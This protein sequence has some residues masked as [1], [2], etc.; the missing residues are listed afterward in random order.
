MKMLFITEK[1]PPVEGGS[2]VYY[3][4][5][6][7]NYIAG[8]IVILTKK[9]EGYKDFD[10]NQNMKIIRKGRPLPNWKYHQIFRMLLT[11]LWTTYL[12]HREKIDVIHCGDFMPAGVIGLLFKK[13]LNKPYVFYVHEG[14]YWYF[15]RYRFKPKLWRL[16]LKNADRIVAA[17]SDAEKGVKHVLN[18]G[19]AKIFKITPGVDYKK[20]KPGWK[21]HDLIRELKLDEKKVILTVGRLVDGRKGHDT[22]IRAMPKILAEVPNAVYLIAGRGPNEHSLRQLASELK[23]ESH[24]KFLGFIPN[25]MIPNVYSVCDVFVMIS[26]ETLDQGTEGFGMVFTEASATGKPVVGGRSGGNED[27]IVDGVTGYR[28]D[29]LNVDEVADRVINLLKDEELRITMGRNGREWVEKNFD[30]RDKA[31]QLERL[32]ISILENK[33]NK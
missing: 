31:M 30:W 6:C 24:V 13:L 18:G 15:D 17:C 22:V 28:V 3:Y 5:L 33:Q 16:I 25:D 7:A 4:N 21:D 29:P 32:N 26:R 19:Y 1:F 10:K 8:D 23:V 27:S 2:R 9:V 14:D 20:F 11:L 12:V